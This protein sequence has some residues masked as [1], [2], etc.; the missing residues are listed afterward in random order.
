MIEELEH[1][2]DAVSKHQVLAHELKLIRTE[3]KI[4][5]MSPQILS[6]I[7]NNHFE[8]G[9]LHYLIIDEQGLETDYLVDMIE[10]VMLEEDE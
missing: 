6:N 1:K 4:I 2:R 9:I 5:I 3:N 8:K 10:L 7:R